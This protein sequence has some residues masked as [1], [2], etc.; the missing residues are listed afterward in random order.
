MSYV[1]K[2]TYDSKCGKDAAQ[3]LLSRFL[4]WSMIISIL[5]SLTG[6]MGIEFAEE[7]PELDN[8]SE[9]NR[10]STSTFNDPALSSVSAQNISGDSVQLEPYFKFF[11]KNESST[12]L[13]GVSVKLLAGTAQT[14]FAH[15]DAT[16]ANRS[17][18][19]INVPSF[20]VDNTIYVVIES[21]SGTIVER[22]QIRNN[23]ITVVRR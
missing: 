22:H 19:V 9:S 23:N 11:L 10:T 7:E 16:L 21:G 3:N 6:C 12:S 14:Q 5:I 1:I 15:I 2:E 17:P 8:P 18:L 13:N 4:F 20:I